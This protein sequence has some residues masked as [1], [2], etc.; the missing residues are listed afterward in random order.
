MRHVFAKSAKH[1]SWRVW[2]LALFISI[3]FVFSNTFLFAR[4]GGT[5]EGMEVATR[6]A[7]AVTLMATEEIMVVMLVGLLEAP[8]WG[9]T[10]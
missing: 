1:L 10:F 7:M 5:V 3:V 6:A 8:S 9:V 4:G 2:T